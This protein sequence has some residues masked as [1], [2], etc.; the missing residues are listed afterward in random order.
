MGIFG[1]IGNALNWWLEPT[2]ANPGEQEWIEYQEGLREGRGLNDD[3]QTIVMPNGDRT[4][5]YTPPG[6]FGADD[7]HSPGMDEAPPPSD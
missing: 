5:L 6:F 4:E 7:A 2:E 1:V 3:H